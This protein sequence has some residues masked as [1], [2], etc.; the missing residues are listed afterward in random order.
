MQILT[1]PV[2]CTMF[3]DGPEFRF[4]FKIICTINV[5]VS[6]YLCRY[7]PFIPLED[8]RTKLFFIILG[9]Y[10]GLDLV[11]IPLFLSTLSF[12]PS[13]IGVSALKGG[14]AKVSLR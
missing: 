1:S 13:K 11:T 12:L 4:H 3:E 10:L 2:P 14:V 7:C 9:Y 6:T 5:C 8:E